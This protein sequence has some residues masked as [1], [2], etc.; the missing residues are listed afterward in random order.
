MCVEEG[1]VG[2]E[3]GVGGEGEG[4]ERREEKGGGRRGREVEG[5]GVWM[6]HNNY[7][8]LTCN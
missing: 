3:G 2:R 1:G 7:E 8:Q 4:V 6:E 5:R